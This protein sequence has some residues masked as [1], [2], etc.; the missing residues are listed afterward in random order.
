MIFAVYTTG[1]SQTYNNYD[2]STPGIMSRTNNTCIERA[3]YQNVF[4]ADDVN[5]LSWYFH[6]NFIVYHKP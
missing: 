1:R 4:K 2:Y 3:L 6:S 5:Q